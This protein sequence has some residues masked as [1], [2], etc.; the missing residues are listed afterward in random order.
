MV[1]GSIP[2]KEWYFYRVK[3]QRS[4]ST[5]VANG[6]RYWCALKKL[7]CTIE[8]KSFSGIINKNTFLETIYDGRSVNM[9]NKICFQWMFPILLTFVIECVIFVLIECYLQGR[10]WVNQFHLLIAIALHLI[11]IHYTNC[12]LSPLVS[13]YNNFFTH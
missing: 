1:R 11:L 3:M 8:Q 2:G 12:I 9:G 10:F 13:L 4:T 6:R 7:K 5:A